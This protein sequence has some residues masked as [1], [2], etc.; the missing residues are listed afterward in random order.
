MLIYLKTSPGQIKQARS[1]SN[2]SGTLSEVTEG[3][4][5]YAGSRRLLK[6]IGMKKIR[7]PILVALG[8]VD[9][10]KTSLLDK[11]RGTAVAKTEPGLIT[12]YISASYIPIQVVRETCGHILEKM[13]TR[14]E[15]PGLLWIDSP[16]HEAF[17]T[18]RKRGGAIADLAILV[19]DI[20]E[21]F[22][23]QTEESIN[24]LKQFRTPFV[25]AAT[26]IDRILG[27]NASKEAC[28]EDAYA[29]QPD[30]AREELENKTYHIIGQLGERG[31]PSERFDRVRD[32]T[33]QISII[34]VSNVTGEG[35]PDLLVMLGGIA[36]RYLK[37]RLEV[38]PGE[39]KGT[40]LEVKEYRGLGT[41]VDVILYDGEISTGDN[42]VI[43]GDEIITT[44]VRA[45]LTPKPLQELRVEKDFTTIP[46]VQ[47][48]AGIK[49][50]AP[51]LEKVIA[52]SP[53]R[54]VTSESDV[55]TAREEVMSEI[56]EVEIETDQEGFIL[57]ADTLGS[58]EAL[59]KTLREAGL[60]IRKARVGTVNKGDIA[61][62]K[63]LEEPIVFA[64]GVRISPEI[65]KL[66]KDNR[67]KI[68]SSDIIYRLIE[69]YDKWDRERKTR[70]ED[71]LLESVTRPGR[72]RILPGYLFRQS[73]PAVFG[74]EVV[75][76]IIR[77]GVKLSRKGE[78]LGEV[79]EIQSRGE[80]VKQAEAGERV[81]LS[82]MGVV[83]G[84]DVN[85]GDE[86]DT[87]ISKHDL[88]TLE[89]L[90]KKLRGDELELM[91]EIQDAS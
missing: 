39:G 10:G 4:R 90:K 12:Q 51:G 6:V 18:L 52:G 14:L 63:T 30:R 80:N 87:L 34:P 16:G 58:L 26:K 75:K 55:E 15:I 47:A 57:K 66:A 46:S 48:A 19:I 35:I 42:L 49:I 31:F 60:S 23:P 73:K 83:F 36:Q 27:W 71:E 2:A 53:L 37:D 9:H 40:V 68:F 84:K 17:T 59:I 56:S 20:N 70:Q 1:L 76:G 7:S 81:A 91:E 28:F 29:N 3:E 62:V 41:T 44:K 33:R 24:Y 11:I 32:F 79:R 77:P 88:E 50:S 78:P 5:V 54:A 21:G 38:S 25:V 43:G 85:E 45:L 64:F 69:D 74:V 65:R 86:L 82:M 61:E 13:G 67:V 89:K 72:V 22:K 8:H